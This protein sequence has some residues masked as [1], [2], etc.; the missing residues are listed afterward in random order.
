M[1]SQQSVNCH[2]EARGQT[3]HNTTQTNLLSWCEP[4]SQPAGWPAGRAGSRASYGAMKR[5]LWPNAGTYSSRA[6]KYVLLSN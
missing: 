3:K 6:L 1:N 5:H 4:A 2:P